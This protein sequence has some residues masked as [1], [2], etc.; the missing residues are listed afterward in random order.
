[1]YK[2]NR[3]SFCPADGFLNEKI[4]A[5]KVK[6]EAFSKIHSLVG[7]SCEIIYLAI[8]ARNEQAASDF[9]KTEK[10]QKRKVIISN[11]K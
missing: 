5:S 1:M 9:R 4:K 7:P 8:L 11:K 6:V 2:G 3:S 10:S